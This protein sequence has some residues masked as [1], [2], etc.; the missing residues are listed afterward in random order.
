MVLKFLKN[1]AVDIGYVLMYA[2]L[3]LFRQGMD[4]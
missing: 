2:N 3:K 4:L 1:G